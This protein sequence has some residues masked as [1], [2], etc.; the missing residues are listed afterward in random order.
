M[1][2]ARGSKNRKTLDREKADRIAAARA[3]LAKNAPAI[4]YAASYDSLD[5]MEK[6]M[7]HFC[8]RALIEEK[9]GNWNAV[10]R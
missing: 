10:G 9:M 2:R 4:D 6:D 7:R 5:V 8:L 1:P 3:E